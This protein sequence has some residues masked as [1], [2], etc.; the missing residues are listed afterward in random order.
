[1]TIKGGRRP[2]A[3][4]KPGVKNKSTVERE[5]FEA[6]VVA[7]AKISGISPLEVML[8][9]MRDAWESGDKKEAASIA[10]DAAPFVHPKLASVTLEGNDEKPLVH[11]HRNVDADAFSS[12]IAGLAARGGEGA[13]A[14]DSEH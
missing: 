10:K 12:R 8:G 1:M 6:K 7:S 5:T 3:G 14:G 9:A 11:E 2:G 13:G 4:R